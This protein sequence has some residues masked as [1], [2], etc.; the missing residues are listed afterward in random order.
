MNKLKIVIPKGRLFK[1]IVNLLND[2]GLGIEETSRQYKPKCSY[3]KI[4]IKI[5]K[6]QN[7]PQLLQFGSH[8]LGFS[9]KDWIDETE[10]DVVEILDLKFDPVK[11]IAAIPFN[12]NFKKLK[13]KK[14]IVASEYERIA[15]NY[16]NKNGFKYCLIRTYGATEVFPPEDADMIIDNTSTGDTLRRNQLEIV[17]ILKKSTTR[18]IANKEALNDEN[19]RKIIMELKTLILSVLD[20][21]DRVMLEMNVPNQLLNIIIS[22]LPCMKSPTIAQLYNNEGYSI[23]ISVK[24]NI[25]AEL[26]P[27]LKQMGATDILETEFRKVIV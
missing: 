7:I 3:S 27:K 11:I 15:K 5:M 13:K 9:G 22:D 21:R 14:I 10:S 4:D 25:T 23:K 8:D 18:M 26:I 16:L 20:A 2:A 6:P 17:D 24:K 1:K 12:T 19:K